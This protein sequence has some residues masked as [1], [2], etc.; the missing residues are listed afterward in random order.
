[1][2]VISDSSPRKSRSSS[3]ACE[4]R[5]SSCPCI[6]HLGEDWVTDHTPS[7]CPNVTTPLLANINVF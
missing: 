2:E 7:A 5:T 3:I 1:M 6:E 4:E